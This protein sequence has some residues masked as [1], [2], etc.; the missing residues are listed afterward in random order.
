[1]ERAK[2]LGDTADLRIRSMLAGF[3]KSQNLITLPTES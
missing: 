2:T 3:S 1:M